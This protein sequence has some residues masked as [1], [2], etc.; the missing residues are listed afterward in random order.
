MAGLVTI[1]AER[2]FQKTKTTKLTNVLRRPPY[3]LDFIAVVLIHSA[4]SRQINLSVRQISLK[5]QAGAQCH[6]EDGYI[7]CRASNGFIALKHQV[8]SWFSSSQLAL[9]EVRLGVGWRGLEL[10]LVA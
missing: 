2:P 6:S 4:F 5:R 10:S 3:T 8:S 9:M 7:Q 1:L